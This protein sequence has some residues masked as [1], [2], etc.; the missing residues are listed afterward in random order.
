MGGF[1]LTK[2]SVC[3]YRYFLFRMVAAFLLLPSEFGKP[4][5]IF[6]SIRM[7]CASLAASS[8]VFSKIGQAQNSLAAQRGT[9]TARVHCGY[10]L[11]TKNCLYLQSLVS[12][13]ENSSEFSP[14][15][16]YS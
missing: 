15:R 4:F 3:F 1:F 10:V 16:N 9:T 11:G 14:Q 6:F 8:P 5:P 13:S 2:T 12:Y 7:I